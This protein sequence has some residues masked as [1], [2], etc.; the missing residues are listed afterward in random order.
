MTDAPSVQCCI[1]SQK[2]S[3]SPQGPP[4]VP[5]IE[6]IQPL[7]DKSSLPADNEQAA[8]GFGNPTNYEMAANPELNQFLLPDAFLV[9]AD[10]VDDR[11]GWR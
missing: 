6:S 11:L 3:Q 1:R 4:G 9:P 8:Q 7:Q 10:G 2:T 5:V